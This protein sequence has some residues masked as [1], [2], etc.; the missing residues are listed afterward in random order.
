MQQVSNRNPAE[1]LPEHQADASAAAH[2]LKQATV[3]EQEDEEDKMRWRVEAEVR[4]AL[5][6]AQQAEA[7]REAYYQR[8]LANLKV[9][10]TAL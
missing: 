2:R 9:L 1:R 7:Q 4:L 3:A 8:E 6:A 5:E 10:S